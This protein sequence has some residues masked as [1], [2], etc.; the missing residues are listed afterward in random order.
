MTDVYADSP[1]LTAEQQAVVDLPA[2]AKALITAA[3]GSGK[4]HTLVRR[5]DA[6]IADHGIAAGEILVLSFSRAAV[7]D[8]S[9]RLATAGQ[10]ARHVRAQTFDSWALL[11]LTTLDATVDWNTRTFDERIRAAEH[12]IGKGAADPLF[13]YGLLHLV[14]DEAQDLVGDRRDLVESLLTRYDCG[15]TVVGDLAQAIYGFQVR[16]PEERVGEAGRFVQWLYRSFEGE[17]TELGLTRDFRALTVEACT[18]LGFGAGLRDTAARGA[19]PRV[20]SR[21]LETLRHA[22]LGLVSIG[23]PADA[24]VR[25]AL[26]EFDG[27][28]AVLCRTNGEALVL[29]ES[30][31]SGGVPHRLQTSGRDRATP[32]WL[33]GL[34]PADAGSLL[35]RD[36]FERLLTAAGPIGERVDPEWAWTLLSRAAREGR[37]PVVGRHRLADLISTGRLPDELT[38]PPSARLI[39]SSI[40]RAKGLEF[41]R[42]IIAEPGSGSAGAVDA[43]AEEAR[44]LY[45]ALTRARYDLFR[46]PAPDTRLVRR[47]DAAGGRWGR[48]GWKAWM[49]PGLEL[50]G[51]DVEIE[52][53]AGFGWSETDPVA[54]QDR[55]RSTVLPGDEVMLE[56]ADVEDGDP[57]RG[58]SY[59]IVHRE[60]LIGRTSAGFGRAL[61]AYLGRSRSI[62]RAPRSILGAH[63]ENIEA[64]RGGRASG[65]VIGAGDYGVWLAPRLG[66]LTRFEY[67]RTEAS[68][69]DE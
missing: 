31:R 51:G 23:D 46:M 6:L 17:L 32:G 48:Y 37:S 68:D 26:R 25:D 64:V 54:I 19:S 30:L 44:L 40:H 60:G 67:D 55:L 2:E 14:I 15:F 62:D 52:T 58:T 22:V 65:S 47:V 12:L 3:A 1:E 56:P 24:I 49:R 9:A 13:E 11:L 53:P 35:T 36:E 34:F 63:V 27:T 28:S 41:D 42:V 66:G 29:S 43:A 33:A 5:L 4:T 10:A 7:R 61:A 18:G 59:R 20:L 69:G 45:V 8:L 39:V 21:Q 57:D 50:R 16:D 38:A